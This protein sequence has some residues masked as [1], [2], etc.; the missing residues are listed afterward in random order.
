MTRYITPDPLARV[1]ERETFAEIIALLEPLDLM[2]AAMRLEGLSDDEIARLL[3]RNRTSVTSRMKRTCQRIIHLRPDLAP[4][5]EGRRRHARLPTGRSR[6]RP[7]EQ[8]WLC[9]CGDDS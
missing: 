9:T 1:I 2:I 4:V 3:G 6:P 8:G 5:L 7:L